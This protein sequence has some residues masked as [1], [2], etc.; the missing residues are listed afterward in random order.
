M[1]TMVMIMMSQVGGLGALVDDDY[2]Y[3]PVWPGGLWAD[4]SEERDVKG[5][6]PH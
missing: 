1:M 6:Q 4:L 5:I 3:K 2:E